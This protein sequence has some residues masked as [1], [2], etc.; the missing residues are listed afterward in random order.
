M[1]MTTFIALLRGINL[2]SHNRISMTALCDLMTQLGYAEVRSLLQS[3]NLV[4]NGPTQ[5]SELLERRLEMEASQRLSLSCDF[6]VRTAAQWKTVVAGNPF[7]RE[8]T[9][10]PAHLQV[11]FL[12]SVPEKTN[13]HALS[14]AITGP[15]IVRALGRELYIV[16]PAGIGKSRLT[17]TVIEKKLDT[18]ATAR[19]WNTVLKVDAVAKELSRLA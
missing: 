10:D 8:A 13:L 16:Y 5:K 2:G 7:Q 15:E 1:T 6:V 14:A 12:R 17:H 4:F 11:V 9:R 18:R 3:G 19:N